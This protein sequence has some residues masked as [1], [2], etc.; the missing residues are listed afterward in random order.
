MQSF[1]RR[2]AH[3]VESKDDLPL[4]GSPLQDLII[5]TTLSPPTYPVPDD[6]MIHAEEIMRG[7]C[8]SYPSDCES[9]WDSS[10]SLTEGTLTPSSLSDVLASQRSIFHDMQAQQPL[11]ASSTVESMLLL[12]TMSAQDVTAILDESSTI[13][14]PQAT[15]L[16]EGDPQRSRQAQSR[17]AQQVRLK[18]AR[19]LYEQTQAAKAKVT[20]KAS[21]P[22]ATT[23]HTAAPTQPSPSMPVEGPASITDAPS[24]LQKWNRW[25]TDHYNSNVKHGSHYAII[26]GGR[27]GLHVPNPLVALW[28]REDPHAP[29]M[30][31]PRGLVALEE[32]VQTPKMMRYYASWLPNEADKCKLFFLCSLDEYRLFWRT[33]TTQSR[34]AMATRLSDENRSRLQTYGR[35]IFAKYLVAGD[36]PFFIGDEDAVDV[37]QVETAISTGGEGALHAFD[38][39]SRL[40]KQHLITSYPA[41]RAT[42]LYRDMLTSCRRE[43]LPL[44]CVLLNRLLCNFFWLF[45]FQHQY[46][47]ELALYIDVQYEFKFLYRAIDQDVAGDHRP[48]LA[49]P[50]C[51]RSKGAA[52]LQYLRRRYFHD[53]SDQDQHA[54]DTDDLTAAHATLHHKQEQIVQKLQDMHSELYFRFI[55]SHAYAE[56]VLYAHDQ[57]STRRLSEL[58]LL[59]GLRAHVSPGGRP[60]PPPLDALP[61]EWIEAIVHFESVPSSPAKYELK[62]TPHFGAAKLDGGGIDAFL[63]PWCKNA[64]NECRIKSLTCPTPF[65]FNTHMLMGDIELF[66]AVL[67]LFRPHWDDPTSFLPYGVA[68]YSRY[69]LH[70]TLR[71]RL[72]EVFEKC[73]SGFASSMI[74]TLSAPLRVTF[75]RLLS[76]PCIDFSLALLFDTLDLTNI[77]TLFT[78]ALVECRILLISSQFTV[79]AV[80]AETLRTILHPLKWPHV[81]VP[82]LPGH[83]LGYLQCPTPFIFG[84]QKD[85]LN[86]EL[87]SELGD[88]VVCV[89]LD[90]SMV[91]QGELPVDLPTPVWKKLHATLRQCLKLHVTKSDHVFGHSFE[92]EARVFPDDRIRLA[93]HD[94][95][96]SIIGTGQRMHISP[97]ANGGGAEGVVD[98]VHFGRFRY[99]WDDQHQDKLVFFDEAGYLASSPLSMRP[100]RTCLIATQA[101]SEYLVG[102]NGFTDDDPSSTDNPEAGA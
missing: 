11:T 24:T 98:D 75:P 62:S 39:I 93:F 26:G 102:H 40:V 35:K 10:R 17:W 46:H 38:R 94:A 20:K 18:A 63:V 73:I 5:P 44:D 81:Y 29:D 85:L 95:V 31:D 41:F 86:A 77:V 84:V 7:S 34:D 47:N 48:P 72:S 57:D 67:T 36:S 66:A 1:Y 90:T 97:S 58:M 51:V 4:S 49:P 13:V 19:F 89:D 8:E 12:E 16:V 28:Q 64:H 56:F 76:L 37:A 45:L 2:Y 71:Q 96:K 61:A 22:S 78:A 30:V 80:V 50:D 74:A 60:D 53:T 32:V 9:M 25:L 23:T 87:L 79:L 82:V 14:P 92:R 70:T 42:D 65:A 68:I 54:L 52:A 91:V 100:F 3:E 21:Q 6:A 55:A 43:L 59:Y 27:R 99:L 69:P 101:F 33:L 15:I 83:M 88:E